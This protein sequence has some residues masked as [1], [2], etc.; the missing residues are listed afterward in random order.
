MLD[1]AQILVSLLDDAPNWVVGCIIQKR[2]LIIRNL[3]VSNIV[4]F[5]YLC[6][7]FAFLQVKHLP[8][9][10]KVIPKKLALAK[11]WIIPMLE[12]VSLL[13]VPGQCMWMDVNMEKVEWVTSKNTG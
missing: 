3:L 7:T 4:F 11:V 8:D 2:I 1:Q 5:I 10:A 13:D 6:F 12:P 9:N